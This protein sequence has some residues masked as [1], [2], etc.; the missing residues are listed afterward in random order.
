MTYSQRGRVSN[1]YLRSFVCGASPREADHFAQHF[2][3]HHDSLSTWGNGIWAVELALSV[4]AHWRCPRPLILA[5]LSPPALAR[6]RRQWRPKSGHRPIRL[7]NP[8]LR[9]H[10]ITKTLQRCAFEVHVSPRSGGAGFP[11][12]VVF[13][14]NRTPPIP[15]VASHMAGQ[16]FGLALVFSH[17]ACLTYAPCTPGRE[18]E[19]DDHRAECWPLGKAP[20]TATTVFEIGRIHRRS[21]HTL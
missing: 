9:T 7:P 11:T 3:N 1:C 12:F 15:V 19:R 17:L 20:P 21:I 8:L 10:S 18:Q 16:S 5:A 13:A 14:T 2:C 4:R 6:P